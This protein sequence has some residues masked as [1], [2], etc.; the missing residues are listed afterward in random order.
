MEKNTGVTFCRVT[1][2]MKP[3]PSWLRS[4]ISQEP[5]GLRMGR[6]HPGCVAGHSPPGIWPRPAGEAGVSF[7]LRLE[8]VEMFVGVGA[9]G[10]PV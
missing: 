1:A 9:A 2:S 5:A 10:G 7:H 6:A 8:F 4:S 3:R